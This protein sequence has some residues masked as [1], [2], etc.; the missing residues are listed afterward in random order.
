MQRLGVSML[1]EV[2][3]SDYPFAEGREKSSVVLTTG[4]R[5]AYGRHDGVEHVDNDA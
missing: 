2:E 3:S 1:C 5:F 4:G